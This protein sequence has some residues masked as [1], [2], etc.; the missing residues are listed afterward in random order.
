M[1]KI[2]LRPYQEEAVSKAVWA[3]D[4]PGN[5]LIVMATGAGKS[6]VIAEY[7]KRLDEPV[8]ILQPSKELLEQNMSKLLHWVDRSEVGVYSASMGEKT[9][10]FYTFATIGSIYKK[11]ELFEHFNTVILDECD[12]L[13]VKNLGGM[14]KKFFD[15]IGNPK[16]LGLTATPYRMDA[17]YKKHNPWNIETITTIKLI[18]RVRGTFWNRILTN[19]NYKELRDQGYLVPLDYIEFKTIEHSQ[20]P[21]NKSKSDFDLEK[22]QELV[23]DKEE[24]LIK[25]IKWA[26]EK[27]NSV[28]VFCANVEQAKRLADKL[29]NGEVIYSDLAGDERKRIVDGFK[30]GSIKVVFNVNILTTGF[31][32]PFL[33]CIVLARPTRSI[34]LYIQMLGRGTRLAEGKDDCLVIDFSGNVKNIGFLDTVRVVKYMGR[35][36][37][38]SEVNG[39]TKKWHYAELYNFVRKKGR[40]ENRN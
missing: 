37:L 9:I 19:V 2:T 21:L 35:W 10:N 36:E 15:G 11:P 3:H 40:Y 5:D 39:K 38:L 20:I 16:V 25:K 17:F 34:R 12:L 18:N 29:E 32:H 28:L 22:Y 6:I 8:L 31:D 4:L 23:A 27:R 14:Y 24:D 1:N 26:S 7:A 30:D 13:N 33:D